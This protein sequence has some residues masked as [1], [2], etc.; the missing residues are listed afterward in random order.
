MEP[1]E[2]FVS[3]GSIFGSNSLSRIRGRVGGRGSVR[4]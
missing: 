1:F 4:P 3:N 2:R